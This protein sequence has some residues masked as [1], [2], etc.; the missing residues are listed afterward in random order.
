MEWGM[1]YWNANFLSH[2]DGAEDAPAD[3]IIML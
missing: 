1:E 2:F 3:D